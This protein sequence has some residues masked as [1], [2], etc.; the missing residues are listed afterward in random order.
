M[1]F[2]GP[3]PADEIGAIYQIQ[4]RILLL[5]AT[6][7]VLKGTYGIN[8]VRQPF[9]GGLK[10]ALE[11]WS[12]PIIAGTEEYKAQ[13]QFPIQLPNPV[14]PSDYCIVTT[15]NHPKGILVKIYYD[16]LGPPPPEG[17]EG[18]KPDLNAAS[19]IQE[20][21]TDDIRIDVLLDG[22][23]SVRQKAEVPSMGQITMRYDDRMVTL[24]SAGIDDKDIV[25]TFKAIQPGFT[26][27]IVEVMGGIAQFHL[28]IYNNVYIWVVKDA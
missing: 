8:F 5:S 21:P 10:F 20:V 3:I 18:Q 16:G 2:L 22:T 4:K 1:G 25:W 9:A 11:G 27:V 19:Q 6:G 28:T 26:Q 17:S 7:K 15:A 14:T 13:T 12:G 24:Q 23:F